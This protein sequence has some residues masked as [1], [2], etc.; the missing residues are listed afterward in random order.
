MTRRVVFT[1]HTFDNLSIERE[2]LDPID[3]ELVD[4]EASDEPLTELLRDADGVLVMY[5]QIDADVIDELSCRVISRTGIGVDNVD[6]D[7]A[8]ERGIYV[9]NVPDYC[10]AEVSDH[11]LALLL[12]LQRKVVTYHEQVENGEWDV[13]AGRPMH[14]LDG[15]T[16]ALV[17]FGAIARAVAEKVQAFGMDVRAHD[18]Y[19]SDEEIREAGVEP[20]PDLQ[21]LFTDADAASVHVPLTE[22]T[23]GLVG[24]RELAAMNSSGYVLNTARG[25]IVD[26][27]ALVDAL[28]AGE[29]AGAG[30]DVLV[31]EPP[32]DDHPL[33]R[34]PRVILT[35]HAAWNSVESVVE[36]RE[37]AAT[38]VRDALEGEVPT[39]LVNRELAE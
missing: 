25:G 21:T 33:R 27:A 24:E 8:T 6:I 36:L 10:I 32:A 39:Y 34:D 2:I 7:A 38:N 29:I 30:L 9:T 1:D 26:E 35:P 31:D 37:K 16:F 23:R 18:P 22:E 15:R 19:L 3:V 13:M 12:G 4:G 5:E 14:R 20:A 17:G 11:T 28:D